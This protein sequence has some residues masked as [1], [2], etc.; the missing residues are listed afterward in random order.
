MLPGECSANF[1]A[2]RD[3]KQPVPG[4]HCCPL[5]HNMTLHWP[6]EECQFFWITHCIIFRDLKRHAANTSFL[7]QYC[8]R[9]FS[10]RQVALFKWCWAYY[11]EHA[12]NEGAST[13]NIS[14]TTDKISTD[15]YPVKASLLLF[16]PPGLINKNIGL[17]YF[18]SLLVITA[19]SWWKPATSFRV[20]NIEFNNVFSARI[21][22]LGYR[23]MI[24]RIIICRLDMMRLNFLYNF[25]VSGHYLSRCFYLK[26]TM[27][28]GLD[29]V[30]VP[31]WNLLIWV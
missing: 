20:K 16:S 26:H 8:T 11:S 25:R 15:K 17:D 28:L 29:S 9:A 12:I 23:V 27:F 4:S 5:G 3:L 19:I 21:T 22:S 10:N 30:S 24:E 31:T 14:V 7:C 2:D 18:C 6:I 1:A 13:W